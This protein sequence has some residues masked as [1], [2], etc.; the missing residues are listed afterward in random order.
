MG[1]LASPAT[2]PTNREWELW[3]EYYSNRVAWVTAVCNMIMLGHPLLVLSEVWQTGETELMGSSFMNWVAL[4][5]SSCW[6][7]YSMF[8]MGSVVWQILVP[9][10][11]GIVVSTVAI[12]VRTWLGY[13]TNPA[14]GASVIVEMPS[15]YTSPSLIATNAES[16]TKSMILDWA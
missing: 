15:I 4:L 16:P 9:N 6:T 11:F 8:Y 12:A 2:S 13:R 7:F 3:L 14:R 10:S 1:S 5:N